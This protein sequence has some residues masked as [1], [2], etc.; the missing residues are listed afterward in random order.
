LDDEIE[1]YI[2]VHDMICEKGHFDL[3]NI[4]WWSM[5]EFDV[6]IDSPSIRGQLTHISWNSILD[7]MEYNLNTYWAPKL[8][9]PDIFA[10]DMW[11]EFS[12]VTLSRMIYTLET[13]SIVSKGEAC[14]YIL[15]RFEEWRDVVQEALA[16][17][18]LE[19]RRVIGNISI[20][21]DRTLGFVEF[22]VNHGNML[23]QE[24]QQK[25]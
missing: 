25:S 14:Q 8:E 4:T 7:T 22:M 19:P 6:A 12:V 10:D 17:R 18:A 15:S 2:Y 9:S 20:R 5:R 21:S 23:M 3:N 11:V 13:D 1:P 24:K 16:I